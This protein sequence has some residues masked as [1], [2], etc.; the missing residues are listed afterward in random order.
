MQQLK[1]LCW[2]SLC[3][4]LLACSDTCNVHID[5]NEASSISRLPGIVGLKITRKDEQSYYAIRE[6][7]IVEVSSLPIASKESHAS[8][9]PRHVSYGYELSNFEYRGSH[10]ISPTGSVV[11]ASVVGKNSHDVRPHHFVVIDLGKRKID[12]IVELSEERTIKGIA[13]SKDSEYFALLSSSAGSSFSLSLVNLFSAMS[14]HP[15]SVTDYFLEIFDRNARHIATV[16]VITGL[17]SGSV[18]VTWFND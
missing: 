6:G 1:V 5:T 11:V 16:N 12:K 14:G 10:L 18:E 8:I 15:V 17:T 2:L 7:V 13:W 3:L 4:T 9:S